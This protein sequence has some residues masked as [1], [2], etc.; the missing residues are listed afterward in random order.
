MLDYLQVFVFF[1]PK[2]F[3]IDDTA[4]TKEVVIIGFQLCWNYLNVH[5][6]GGGRE[7]GQASPPFPAITPSPVEV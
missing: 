4:K 6:Q 5:G 1:S 3:L 2:H 7:E